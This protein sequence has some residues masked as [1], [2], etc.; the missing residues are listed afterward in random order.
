MQRLWHC[1]THVHS[2]GIQKHCRTSN[3]TT[4]R[5]FRIH[6]FLL[7]IL[8]H[9]NWL[10]FFGPYSGSFRKVRNST[11]GIQ[12]YVGSLLCILLPGCVG[13]DSFIYVMK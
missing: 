9:G 6:L 2:R 11:C 3:N 1:V 5:L 4:V 7:R 10:N 8:W 13:M 12:E